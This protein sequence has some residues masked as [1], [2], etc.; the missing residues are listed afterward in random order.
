MIAFALERS[1]PL[2]VGIET[3]AKRT[4]YL[5]GST[6]AWCCIHPSPWQL[7]RGVPE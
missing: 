1:D 2:A 5:C 7:K 4:V 6:H 3:F